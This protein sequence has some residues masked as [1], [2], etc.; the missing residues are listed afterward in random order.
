MEHG[1]G[2]PLGWGGVGCGG[3]GRAGRGYQSEEYINFKAHDGG[4]SYRR[5]AVVPF[6]VFPALKLESHQKLVG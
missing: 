2:P 3:G 6:P 4:S 5:L 1:N